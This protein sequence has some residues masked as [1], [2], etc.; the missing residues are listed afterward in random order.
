MKNLSFA[1]ISFYFFNFTF[2]KS[3]A[4]YHVQNPKTL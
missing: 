2:S 4:I 1:Q 3:K